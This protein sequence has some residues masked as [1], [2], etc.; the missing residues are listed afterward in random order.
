LIVNFSNR[1]GIV[2]TRGPNVHA[3]HA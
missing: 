3:V 2:Y 1:R